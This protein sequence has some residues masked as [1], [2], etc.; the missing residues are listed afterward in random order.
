VI[1]VVLGLV[2]WA[3]VLIGVLPFVFV[4]LF[5]LSIHLKRK[6]L[7]QCEPSDSSEHS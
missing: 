5:F 3:V 6:E 4:G 1:R 7:R 2:L